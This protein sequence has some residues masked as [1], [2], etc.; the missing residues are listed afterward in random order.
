[1]PI[2]HLRELSTHEVEDI[3]ARVWCALEA[4]GLAS[5][6]LDMRLSRTGTV[7]VLLHFDTL[8]TVKR[9]IHCLEASLPR[10]VFSIIS[11][12]VEVHR[13]RR[14]TPSRNTRDRRRR[15][16]IAA[17]RAASGEVVPPFRSNP[18]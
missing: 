3:L 4:Y 15:K 2:I 13:Q 12:N 1:M 11:Q 17:A 8:P 16:R 18:V 10:Q 5:P 7:D 6:T 14:A 9:I